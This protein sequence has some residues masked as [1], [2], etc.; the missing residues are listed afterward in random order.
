[1]QSV[2]HQTFSRASIWSTFHN[3]ENAFTLTFKRYG[4]SFMVYVA[5]SHIS[6]SNYENIKMLNDI[7][8]ILENLTTNFIELEGSR[9]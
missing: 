3:N 7:V 9:D 6:K 5:V 8:R 4:L 2:E 1:M